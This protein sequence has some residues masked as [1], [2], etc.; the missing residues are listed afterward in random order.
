[1]DRAVSWSLSTLA[2]ASSMS[3]AITTGM[4]RGVPVLGDGRRILGL[5]VRGHALDHVGPEGG[6]A[7][8]EAVDVRLE[9]GRVDGHRRRPH[10][11]E[12][13]DLPRPGEALLEELLADQAVRLGGAELHVRGEARAEQRP[14]GGHGQDDEH[15][16]EADGAPRVEGAEARQA[17]REAAAPAAS[18]RRGRVACAATWSTPP[19]CFALSPMTVPLARSSSRRSACGRTRPVVGTP[20]GRA[21]RR[22]ARPPC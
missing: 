10:D 15:R 11:H 20:A 9:G 13:G 18:R 19:V 5:V 12:V 2:S 21:S 14:D 16:P 22:R 6:D 7:R 17:L 1:M 3:P 8:G 4:Q